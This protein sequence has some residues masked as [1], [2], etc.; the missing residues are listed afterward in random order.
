MPPKPKPAT[1]TFSIRMSSA[2]LA[3]IRAKPGY[4]AWA[5]E[6]LAAALGRPELA[7]VRPVGNPTLLKQGVRRSRKAGD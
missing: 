2:L 6:A 4:S 3:A 5:R 1:A 7:D